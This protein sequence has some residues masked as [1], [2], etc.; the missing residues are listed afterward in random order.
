MAL[1]APVGGNSEPRELIEAGTYNARCVQIIQL[2]TITQESGQYAGKSS[3]KLRVV[4]ELVDEK[5][6]FNPE[7]G[8]QPLWKDKEYTFS[9]YKEAGLRKDIEAWRG[10]AFTD[11]EA[12]K[13]D[14]DKL[15]GQPCMVSIAH[16][17][18]DK[19]KEYDYITSI[20]KAMKGVIVA[21]LSNDP[22]YLSYND[23][24]DEL[25][26]SLPDWLRKKMEATP[27]FKAM[28]AAIEAQIATPPA[29][30]VPQAFLDATAQGAMKPNADFFASA[31]AEDDEPLF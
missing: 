5:R 30:Q 3:M 1:N 20:S 10:K 24:N 29:V 12:G 19:G 23:W 14:I 21:P 4:W 6:T 16:K 26:L 8:E 11:D 9:M 2:G 27:E 13:F 17:K 31:P 28:D 15:L 25:F 7:K 18:S 22:V